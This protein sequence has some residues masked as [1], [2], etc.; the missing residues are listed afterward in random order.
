MSAVHAYT[1]VDCQKILDEIAPLLG[2]FHS[3]FQRLERLQELLSL[4]FQDNS[5]GEDFRSVCCYGKLGMPVPLALFNALCILPATN[6]CVQ[7]AQTTTA[8]I[9]SPRILKEEEKNKYLDDFVSTA[10]A[11]ILSILNEIIDSH[12]RSNEILAFISEKDGIPLTWSLQIIGNIS[13]KNQLSPHCLPPLPVLRQRIRCSI[14]KGFIARETD[15]Q[16]RLFCQKTGAM[17]QTS[18][19][20]TFNAE[21]VYIKAGS[22]FKDLLQNRLTE[23]GKTFDELAGV[24]P[25]KRYPDVEAVV[26]QGFASAKLKGMQSLDLKLDDGT[27]GGTVISMH[28]EGFLSVEW[29]ANYLVDLD[30]NPFM[31]DDRAM[32][33]NNKERYLRIFSSNHDFENPTWMQFGKKSGVYLYLSQRASAAEQSWLTIASYIVNLLIDDINKRLDSETGARFRLE[34]ILFDTGVSSL[35]DPSLGSFARHQDGF[36]G[37]IDPLR[38]GFT[39]YNLIVPTTAFQNHFADTTTITWFKKGDVAGKPAGSVKHDFFIFH[40]QLPGVNHYFE[41]EVRCTSRVPIYFWFNASRPSTLTLIP[42]EIQD[43]VLTDWSHRPEIRA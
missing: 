38:R 7:L 36:P 39:R 37:L 5:Q 13:N 1:A 27:V 11:N 12:P 14:D 15:N 16:L 34:Q 43:H 30:Q 20:D 25:S 29:I 18:D 26:R 42:F 24:K 8:G 22:E 28:N 2:L 4:H 21:D 40:W 41:H 6:Y 23:S 17:W 19:D 10:S 3:S 35:A 31:L 32:K 9:I 33:K